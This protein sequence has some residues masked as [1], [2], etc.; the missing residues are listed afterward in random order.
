[1]LIILSKLVNMLKLNSTYGA[2]L[3]SF[4]SNNLVINSP[5]RDYQFYDPMDIDIDIDN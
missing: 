1:M 2:S 3:M 5:N 4:D